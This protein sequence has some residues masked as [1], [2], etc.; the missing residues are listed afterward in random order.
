MELDYTGATDFESARA[1]HKA[2]WDNLHQ[3]VADGKWIE[4]SREEFFRQ[5]AEVSARLRKENEERERKEREQK[6]Q[7]QKDRNDQNTSGETNPL[8]ID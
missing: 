2:F 1:I 7:E 5:V 3:E 8:L 4:I 6:D